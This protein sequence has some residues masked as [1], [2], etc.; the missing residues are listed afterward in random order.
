MACARA[1]RRVRPDHGAGPA[2]AAR[3][4]RSADQ[5][6][7]GEM[8]VGFKAVQW[9]GRKLI[10][11]V[12]VLGCAL[13]FIVSFVLVQSRL[14]PPNN[15]LDWIDLRINACG[16]CAF[17]MLTIILSIG[18]LARLD[19]RFLPLLYNRRHFGVMMF[20][21]APAH[22]SFVVEWFA[23][24]GALHELWQEISQR[25]LGLKI[26]RFSMEVPGLFAL[27]SPV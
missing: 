11:D 7:A 24:R 21:V 2:S 3:P 1:D 16:V 5:P 12:I 27:S 25:A 26:I 14:T 17:T 18:P 23:E 20:I 19:K 9:N 13:T 6:G 10:Y 8:S 4:G 22:A 15:N